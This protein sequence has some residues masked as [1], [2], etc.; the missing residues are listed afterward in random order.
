MS[1]KNKDNNQFNISR[2]LEILF[3]NLLSIAEEHHKN[4]KKGQKFFEK[5]EKNPK[6]K[7]SQEELKDITEFLEISNKNK[8]ANHAFLIYSF[9]LFEQFLSGLL[10]HLIKT[11]K[12]IKKIYFGAWD[13]LLKS[14][15]INKYSIKIENLMD[16]KWILENYDILL[17]HEKK[18]LPRFISTILGTST[19]VEK[20]D[21]ERYIAKYNLYR[22]VRNLLAHRGNHF[23]KNFFDDVKKNRI[24]KDNPDVLKLFIRIN[25]TEKHT[26]EKDLIDKPVF[27]RLTD[28]ITSLL[29]YASWFSIFAFKKERETDVLTFYGSVTHDVMCFAKEHNSP[30][31]II[32]RILFEIYKEEVFNGNVKE[33][34]DGD[35]FNYFLSLHTELSLFKK[36]LKDEKRLIKPSK[37]RLEKFNEDDFN[38]RYL[39]K[40]H[41]NLLKFYIFNKKREFLEEFKNFDKNLEINK[42]W[43][44]WFIFKRW[45]SDLE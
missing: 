4:S 15:D 11:D 24:I 18:T 3:D 2:K 6:K 37:E 30:M 13:R 1:K 29:F 9:S 26:D 16:D 5:I 35:K 40:N 14:G 21:S 27:F 38:L 17:R 28:A 19:N 45:M 36:N 25:S 39:T 7:A 32:S 23:D 42:G 31:S 22:E 10:K 20:K 44:K 34:E 41:I 43:K 8:N 12:E 33:M